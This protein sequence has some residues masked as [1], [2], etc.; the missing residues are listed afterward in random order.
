MR[1]L[2]RRAVQRLLGDG[3]EVEG[4]GDGHG[5]EEGPPAPRGIGELC[6]RREPVHVAD[7]EGGDPRLGRRRARGGGGGEG[8][9]AAAA[10][11]AVSVLEEAKQAEA[12]RAEV[13]RVREDEVHH[14]HHAHG[15]PQAAEQPRVGQTPRKVPRRVLEGS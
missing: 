2:L 5:A 14:R 13:E 1:L 15:E 10:V 7:V 3:E 6:G 8:C 9:G 4:Y 12:E 11:V